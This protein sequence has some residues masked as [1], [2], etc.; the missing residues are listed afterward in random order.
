MDKA[1][2]KFKKEVLFYLRLIIIYLLVMEGIGLWGAEQSRQSRS[3][4][5]KLGLE[6]D[7]KVSE[8]RAEQWRYDKGMR[9]KYGIRPGCDGAGSCK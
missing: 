2:D 9:S 6:L 1:D 3:E 5:A 4:Q 7:K 8:E